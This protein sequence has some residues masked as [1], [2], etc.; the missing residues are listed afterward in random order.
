MK[1]TVIMNVKRTI[2]KFFKVNVLALIVVTINCHAAVSDAVENAGESTP[3]YAILEV[4][5]L[6]AN[7]V[8][9]TSRQEPVTWHYTLQKPPENWIQP[10]FDD[11]GWQQGPGGFGT[12]G[13]PGAIVR[14]T[15]NTDD[16]WL[17]RTFTMPAGNFT[18]LQF[19]VYHDDDVEIY[20]NGFP[21]ASEAGFV[22]N[23]EA[24][25]ISS[26]ARVVLQPGAQIT[27]SV[28]CHQ[29]GGGQGVDVGLAMTKVH[30]TGVKIHNETND[31]AKAPEPSDLL[32][33]H[34]DRLAICGDSI[35]EQKMYSRIIEDY[36]TMC[37]PQLDVSVRQYGWSGETA[38]GF[39]WRMSND[40]L[41]F[42]PTI[43][44]TCYGM[45]DFEYRAYEDRIG[46][47]YRSN[48]VAIVKAFK[49]HG[50]R[51]ILGSPGCVGYA[52]W[53]KPGFTMDQLNLSLG[54][55]RNIDV[56]IAEQKK[57][58]FADVFSPMMAS[59]V[60]SLREYGSGYALTGP[61]GV[62]PRWAGHTIMAYAFLNAMGLNG[63]IGTFT[64]NLKKKTMKASA[65][66]KLISSKDDEFEI[67]SS[68][69]P[70]CP[71]VPAEFSADSYPTC[72]KDDIASNDS[73][74]SGMTLVPFN[75]D[76]NRLML[77]ATDG[78]AERY[79]VTWGDQTKAFTAE[80][81][82]QGINLTEEFPRNP[83]SGQFARV[84]AA[85]AAKQAYETAE[86]QQLF[87]PAG[88]DPSME[89]IAAQ[90]DKVVTEAEEKHTTLEAA[91]HAAF[92]PVTYTI[93]IQAVPL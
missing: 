65:G 55:L 37:V 34:G 90:T 91:V 68:R 64:V 38:S 47:A 51:V 61:D 26:A 29:F 30:L 12:E 75:Q 8:V 9:P 1:F 89:Q 54:H 45:N 87:R 86:I 2:N 41:R 18:N 6:I 42:K 15:W 36:L 13:T 60:A 46:T 40:C 70:F 23:Y 33:K 74:R 57:T 35:T 17:R 32:L 72:G 83:F 53:R 81:L 63:E 39:L 88:Q 71:C 20:I 52:F 3:D 11:S 16:I 93:K 80:Q 67:Q 28:H 7:E 79:Q 31:L 19:Y 22:I 10:S 14:T 76:L 44:T 58:G 85:V 24:L 62:H 84:D 73:I 56:E 4:P 25:A 43:A 49:A 59:S 69:Y 66:H 50:A 21:A 78:T 27:L 77:V 92:V 5:T 82:A 48:T